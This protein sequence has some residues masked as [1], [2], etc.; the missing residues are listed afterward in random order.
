V[1]AVPG[2]TTMEIES[3]QWWHWCGSA[4]TADPAKSLVVDSK[5]IKAQIVEGPVANQCYD[6]IKLHQLTPSSST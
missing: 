1:Q 4:R 5:I 3:G 2:A 6:E